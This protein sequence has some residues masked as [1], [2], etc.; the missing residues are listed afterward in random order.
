MKLVYEI[1]PHD[2]NFWSGA[3]DRMKHANDEQRHEVLARIQELAEVA[4][5]SGKPLT[6]VDINDYVWFECDDIF[7]EEV[8]E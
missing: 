6:D 1:D 2:F 4:A 3:Y 8:E 7:D 5:E